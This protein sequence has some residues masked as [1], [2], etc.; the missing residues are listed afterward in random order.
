MVIFKAIGLLHVFCEMTKSGIPSSITPYLS[1]IHE[2]L[3][4]IESTE[5]LLN[6]T[7]IRKYRIKLAGRLS[8]G[9]L[10]SRVRTTAKGIPLI[11]LIL[12]GLIFI[13]TGRRLTQASML[14]EASGDIPEDLI[15]PDEVESTISVL[16]E[17]LQDKVLPYLFF[18]SIDVL[19]LNRHQEYRCSLH[20][21]EIS[22][23]DRG[24]T[25]LFFVSANTRQR[26]RIVF[27]I[28]NRDRP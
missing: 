15:I 16:L 21:F 17:Y 19:T 3:L 27:H 11:K 10:P 20:C 9:V 13:K 1:N 6:N 7:V 26:F 8:L 25:T 22:C 23:Q 28:P 4:R 18:K 12:L 2:V 24:T 5:T 14:P